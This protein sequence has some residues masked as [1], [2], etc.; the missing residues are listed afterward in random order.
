MDLVS[1]SDSVNFLA[2]KGP[3]PLDLLHKRF[4]HISCARLVRMQD[5][6]CVNGLHILSTKLPTCIC[7]VCKVAMSK[8]VPHKLPVSRKDHALLDIVA[9]DY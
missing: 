8:S 6:C 1:P 5:S 7:A 2:L 4:A 9:L 3:V